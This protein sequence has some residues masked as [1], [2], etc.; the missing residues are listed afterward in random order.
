[1]KMGKSKLNLFGKQLNGNETEHEIVA[2][3][4]LILEKA[5]LKSTQNF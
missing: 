2:I 4:I 1:M 3:L 5:R